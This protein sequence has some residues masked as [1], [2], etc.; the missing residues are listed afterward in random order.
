[1]HWTQLQ[2]TFEAINNSNTEVE[3]RLGVHIKILDI[4]DHAPEF[5]QT[6]YQVAVNESEPQGNPV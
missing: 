4:N 3:T 6:V 1:M 5:Q 2:S